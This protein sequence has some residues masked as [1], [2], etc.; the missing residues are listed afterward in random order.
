MYVED[1]AEGAIL[2]AEARQVGTDI[3][4]G[5]GGDAYDTGCG[6]E[7]Q[8]CGRIQGQDRHGACYEQ[9]TCIGYAVIQ[10]RQ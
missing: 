7:D 5:H 2:A 4:V 8:C 1:V 9:A 6:G 3:R 10:A